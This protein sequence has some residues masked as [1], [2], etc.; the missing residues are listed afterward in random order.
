MA[1]K[2]SSKDE[3]T[4]D[5]PVETPVTEERTLT[6][7][8]VEEAEASGVVLTGAADKWLCIAKAVNEAEGWMRST[9]AMQIGAA[10]CLVQT[11]YVWTN[12]DGT[13]GCFEAVCFAP[14]VNLIEEAG[15]ARFLT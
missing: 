2:K 6:S 9:K 15:K 4:A 12:P 7:T 8:T 3:A 11:S 5:V 14:S 1:E 10:G 13:K